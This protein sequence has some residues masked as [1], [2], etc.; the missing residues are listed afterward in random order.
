MIER[1]I[2]RAD[3]ARRWKRYAMSRLGLAMDRLMKNG[4]KTRKGGTAARRQSTLRL[5]GYLIMCGYLSCYDPTVT[6]TGFE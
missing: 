2:E 4:T 6:N 1:R 5:S 3:N